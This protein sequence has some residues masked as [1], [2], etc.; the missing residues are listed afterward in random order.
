MNFEFQ[1][2]GLVL[3]IE[4]FLNVSVT[5]AM[6]ILL[7]SNK[8][9]TF[10]NFFLPEHQGNQIIHVVQNEQQRS[11]ALNLALLSVFSSLK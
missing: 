11:H 4:H 3:T 9:Q 10:L 8:P 5:R 6:F 7:M 2:H 1:K